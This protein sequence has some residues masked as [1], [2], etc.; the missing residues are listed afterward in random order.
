MTGQAVR[1]SSGTSILPDGK[2]IDYAPGRR[3]FLIAS[4][5]Y[6][7][8]YSQAL[9]DIMRRHV[10]DGGTLFGM[11]TGAWLMAEAGLLNGR[12]ATIHWDVMSR[13]EERFLSVTAENRPFVHDDQMRTCGGAMAAFDLM[14]YLISQ[15][16]GAQVRFDVESLFKRPATLPVGDELTG[17]ALTREAIAIMR[18]NL[19]TPIKV[20]ELARLLSVHPKLLERVFKREFGLPSGQ[21]YKRLRLNS[22]RDLVENTDANFY[23][24]AVRSGYKSASAMTRA[25]SSEFGYTPSRLRSKTRLYTAL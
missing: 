23:D 9:G 1:S 2:L 11:D 19:E 13:F 24:I 6:D 18:Q 5:G 8:I 4:Y 21:V 20:T 15:D 25:F 22:V 16:C 10:Y 17:I 3:L 14:L 12:A 7:T